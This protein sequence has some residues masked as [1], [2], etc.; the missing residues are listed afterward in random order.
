MY[1]KCLLCAF[2]RC[3]FLVVELIEV[4]C[5]LF[6]NLIGEGSASI[7]RRPEVSDRRE[8]SGKL[9]LGSAITKKVVDRGRDLS[10]R[11]YW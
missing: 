5:I 11:A 3:A 8:V 6:F 9:R 2:V 10:V 1:K 4:E 7:W